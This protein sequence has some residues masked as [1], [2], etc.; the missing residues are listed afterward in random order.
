MNQP[1]QHEH[2]EDCTEAVNTCE[3]NELLAKRIQAQGM[4]ISS[5]SLRVGVTRSMVSL[6]VN[7]KAKPS[8]ELMFRIARELSCDTRE[9]FPDG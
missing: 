1:K 4:T 8:R 6:V 3:R 2:E 9:V 7:G 5:F